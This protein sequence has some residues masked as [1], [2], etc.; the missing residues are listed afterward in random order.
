LGHVFEGEMATITN[1]RH[2]VNSISIKFVS[3][4]PPVPLAEAK[5]CPPR[6]EGGISLMSS[7]TSVG[8]VGVLLLV[9]AKVLFG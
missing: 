1:E 3:G 4:D 9:L 7:F 8:A 5:V 2:C 6:N